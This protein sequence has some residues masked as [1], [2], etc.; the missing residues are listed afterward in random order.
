MSKS[1]LSFF[2]VSAL[3]SIWGC[4]LQPEALGEEET[5]CQGGGSTLRKKC[6]WQTRGS[7]ESASMSCANLQRSPKRQPAAAQSIHGR[8]QRMSPSA[9]L[10]ASLCTTRFRHK[11]G[12]ASS[13]GPYGHTNPTTLIQKLNNS[14]IL[15]RIGPMQ[16]RD[17]R[18]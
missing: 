2:S 7:S 15:C 5:E 6:K 18:K 3:H 17:V 14:V 8:T 4:S 9:A 11:V 16:G 10:C 13:T 1:A 12:R